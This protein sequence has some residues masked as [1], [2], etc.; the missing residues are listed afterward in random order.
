MERRITLCKPESLRFF[1]WS[2]FDGQARA[3]LPRSVTAAL[4]LWWHWLRESKKP[5][6]NCRADGLKTGDLVDIECDPYVDSGQEEK[7]RRMYACV[8]LQGTSLCDPTKLVCV[9]FH[10]CQ[11]VL[12]PRDHL[13]QIIRPT[14][15]ELS[16]YEGR[17]GPLGSSREG[18]TPAEPQVAVAPQAPASPAA[19]PL[20]PA[21]DFYAEE[22]TP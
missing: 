19:P 18:A 13:L 7:W 20:P 14:E 3:T 10:N 1:G 6:E 16:E 9:V 12:W 22:A 15:E 2:T 5:M 21:K 17:Y 8:R 4:G 11:P